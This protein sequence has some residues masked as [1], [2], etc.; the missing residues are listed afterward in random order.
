M[1]KPSVKNEDRDSE[2]TPEKEILVDGI[3]DV[4]FEYPFF[5]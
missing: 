3:E 4:E 5:Q 1:P 2:K